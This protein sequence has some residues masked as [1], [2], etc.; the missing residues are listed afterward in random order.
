MKVAP[1]GTIIADLAG[2]ATIVTASLAPPTE[3]EAVL[4]AR[5]S[6]HE[7]RKA[8]NAGWLI[9]TGMSTR[10]DARNPQGNGI[11]CEPGGR[12]RMLASL[13]SDHLANHRGGITSPRRFFLRYACWQVLPEISTDARTTN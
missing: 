10:P 2:T 8:A 9:S 12:R 3:G 13:L 5:L 4:Y 1:T 6:R 11:Y 7:E